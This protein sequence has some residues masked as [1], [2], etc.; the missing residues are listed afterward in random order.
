LTP[1][2]AGKRIRALAERVRRLMPMSSDPER[3]HL[4]KSEIEA[5]LAT[6]AGEMDPRRVDARRPPDSK[7]TPGEIVSAKGRRVLAQ[8]RG[9]RRRPGSAED[10][11]K[12]VFG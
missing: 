4:E 2:E 12:A 1:A 6:L 9:A 5:D 10:L 8:T 11:K 7:F 3:F